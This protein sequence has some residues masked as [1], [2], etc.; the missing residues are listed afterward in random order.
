[1]S[2][3]TPQP[4]SSSPAEWRTVSSQ[5]QTAAPVASFSEATFVS[6]QFFSSGF[7][8]SAKKP[9]RYAPIVA[10]PR[11]VPTFAQLELTDSG[12]SWL[13]ITASMTSFRSGGLCR[14][15]NV[16]SVTGAR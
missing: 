13:A 3:R 2:K 12:T 10:S 5:R 8:S 4:H 11:V 16:D 15:V 14:I 6:S 9:A 7:D 1:M